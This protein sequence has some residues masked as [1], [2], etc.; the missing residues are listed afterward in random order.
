MNVSH[1]P[2]SVPAYSRGNWHVYSEMVAPLQPYGIRGVIWY[3]GE[4]NRG[5]HDDY[6]VWFPAMIEAWRR[7]WGQG[8]FPFL[9]VQL[10]RFG[11]PEP[12]DGPEPDRNNAPMREAQAKALAVKNTAMIVYYD[13]TDGDTHT[14]FKQPCGQRLALAAR[15]LAYGEKIEYSGPQ[16]RSVRWEGEKLVVSFDHADGLVA[17]P[18]TT[19]A[20]GPGAPTTGPTGSTTVADMYVTGKDGGVLRIRPPQVEGSAVVVDLTGQASQAAMLYY[21]WRSYPQG[22]LFNTAG[23]PA[24]P[25]RVNLRPES[26]TL[27]VTL[28]MPKTASSR[29]SGS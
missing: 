1:P 6:A 4:G 10:P 16:F 3:Q 7:A 22:N 19:V 15:A 26:S 17:G 24:A 13:V 9:F 20:V 11:R 23:L 8:D 5:R 21:A 28:P 29:A 25:F 27:P 14:R 18:P 2:K 12:A